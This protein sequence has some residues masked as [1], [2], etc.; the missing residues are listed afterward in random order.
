MNRL[1]NAADLGGA[2]IYLASPA[3]AWVTGVILPVDGKTTRLGFELIVGVDDEAAR[4][5]VSS[6]WC[7]R[8]IDKFSFVFYVRNR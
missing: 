4:L 5:G 8:K 6:S 1:G 3:G 2:A 7:G